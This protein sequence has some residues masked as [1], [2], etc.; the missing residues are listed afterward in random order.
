[1]LPRDSEVDYTRA[2]AE[3]ACNLVKSFLE[4]YKKSITDG[5]ILSI[6]EPRVKDRKSLI[7]KLELKEKELDKVSDIAGARIVCNYISDV[8]K[9]VSWLK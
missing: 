7:K 8:R 1:M 5:V 6:E 3:R 4:N 2:L 9:V